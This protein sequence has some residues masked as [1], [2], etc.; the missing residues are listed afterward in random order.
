MSRYLCQE[1]KKEHE[2]PPGK[3]VEPLASINLENTGLLEGS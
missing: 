2:R 3:G 1:V